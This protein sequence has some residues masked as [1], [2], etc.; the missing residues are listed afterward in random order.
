MIKDENKVFFSEN[1]FVV[2]NNFFTEEETKTLKKYVESWINNNI[3][4]AFTSEE[5]RSLLEINNFS[6]Y[7][8]FI[9]KNKID[10]SKVASAQYRYVEP[11][12]NIVKII[13]KKLLF[14]YLKLFTGFDS[15][16][17]WQDPGFGWLGYR[18]IRAS[19]NDG[20]P[21][22]CKN[23]G[24]ARDVYSIWLPISG[25]NNNSNIRFLPGSHKKIFENYMPENSKFTK[26]EFRLKE[27]IPDSEYIR[28]IVDDNGIIIYHPAC[29][30]SEDSSDTK[31]TR[32]NLEYRFK[33]FYES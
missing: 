13:H 25:C 10:H 22:S 24:A 8:D 18:L 3:S 19:S 26:G 4:N 27:N 12:E 30:H 9:V 5:K 23:W 6:T 14:E 1:G 21:P 32:L 33:P 15:Y 7:H 2:I 17:K 20:Y 31:N 16:I 29:I 11:S 28:P